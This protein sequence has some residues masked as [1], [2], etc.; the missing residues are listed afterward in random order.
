VSDRSEI[1]TGAPTHETGAPA[2]HHRKARER[3]AVAGPKPSAPT[4]SALTC[5]TLR[6]LGA[7]GY[8]TIH[9]F[10]GV[11]G[12]LF[13]FVPND[14][15]RATRLNLRMCLP[16]LR[17]EERRRLERDSLVESGRTMLELG[18]LW[19]W[20]RERVLALVREVDGLELFEEARARGRGVLLLTPHLG[21]WELAGLYVSSIAPITAMYKPPRHREMEAF[22]NRA[23][24]RLGARLVPADASGV[25]ALHRALREG[26]VAGV[27]PDQDPGHGSG[28]FVPFFG[29]LANTTTLVAKLA[30]KTGSPVLLTWAERLEGG[31]G[32]RMHFVEPSLPELSGDD[33][34]AAVRAMNRELERLIRGSPRQY[35]W[36]YKRFRYRPPGL[37]NPYRHG[38]AAHTVGARVC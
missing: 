37:K 26:E 29:V 8:R 9:R 25:R 16:E 36:S 33:T 10:G 24:E 38:I 12:R 14:T 5:T 1:P 30:H 17:E 18:A 15:R 31:A 34:E 27:L 6:M 13:T 20:P 21:A 11:A 32:F 3:E 19:C 2:C 4:R 23:R 22:F 28:L 7:L 35:L